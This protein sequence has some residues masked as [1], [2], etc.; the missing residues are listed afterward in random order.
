MRKKTKILPY[1]VLGIVTIG[2]LNQTKKRKNKQFKI[3]NLEKAVS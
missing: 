3:H 1:I 2:I